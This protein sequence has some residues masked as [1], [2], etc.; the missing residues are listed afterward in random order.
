[1]EYTPL[2]EPVHL[3]AETHIPEASIHYPNFD[4]LRLLLALEVMLVH[5]FAFHGHTFG[6]WIINPVPAFV[7]ISGF[8]VLRSFERSHTWKHFA[9]KRLCRVLPA[10]SVSLVLVGLLAGWIYIVPT[11]GVYAT[12]GIGQ[13][14]GEKNGALWSLS[15]EEVLYAL[16]A[17][18]FTLGLYRRKWPIWIWVACGATI[19][20]AMLWHSVRG[21]ERIGWVVAS[22]PIGSLVYLYRDRLSK[23]NPWTW[24]ALLVFC[25]CAPVH[26]RYTTHLWTMLSAFAVVGFGAFGPRFPQPKW[27]LSY[28]VYVYHVPLFVVLLNQP[29]WIAFPAVLAVASLSW[30]VIE[31]PALRLKS[32]NLFKNKEIADIIVR[33]SSVYM[34]K[35][36]C[37]RRAAVTVGVNDKNELT[38]RQ[39]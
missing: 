31:A 18:G 36:A 6:R 16:L 12:F 38:N 13:Y 32:M 34:N 5:Y 17:I 39:H 29:A 9:W 26:E 2:T 22:F 28:G 14:A 23:F 24:L 37:G 35:L 8:L 7:S 21:I 4:L 3:S 20:P 25:A 10:F 1:M 11:L 30:V 27:D 19:V 33:R 15:V